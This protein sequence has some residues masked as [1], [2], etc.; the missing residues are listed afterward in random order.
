MHAECNGRSQ[1]KHHVEFVVVIRLMTGEEGQPGT[2]NPNPNRLMTGEEGQGGQGAGTT[3]PNPNPNRGQGAGTTERVVSTA[4]LYR[5]FRDFVDLHAALQRAAESD[6]QE[7][8]DVGEFA[9][10]GER[11]LYAMSPLQALP[12]T[13]PALPPR[14]L[15]PKWLTNWRDDAFLDQRQAQLGA[16]I[17]LVLLWSRGAGPRARAVVAAFLQPGY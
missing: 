2:T 8:R 5:R 17:D 1:R 14:G 13:L 4:L 12:R 10:P 7:A 6:A 11:A 9:R 16:W 15:V 3:N